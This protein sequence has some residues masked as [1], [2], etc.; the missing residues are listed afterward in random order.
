MTWGKGFNRKNKY[1]GS[2]REKIAHAGHWFDSKLE[3]ALYDLLALRQRGGEIRDLTHQP[4][5]V[6]LSEARVQYRPDF[7]FI[8]AKTGETQYAESKGFPNDRWPMKKKLWKR[9]GP[10]KLEIWMGTVLRLRLVEVI[11]PQRGACP[12]CGRVD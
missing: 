2:Q 9:Y 7:R 6:F 5:T 10:G 8:D 1:G 4:G 11:E 3:A 12:T